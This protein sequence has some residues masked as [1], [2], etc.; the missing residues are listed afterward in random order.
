M[1]LD[2]VFAHPAANPGSSLVDAPAPL[3][4]VI[5][6]DDVPAGRRAL[7]ML[8]RVL[9]HD[10]AAVHLFPSLWRFDLLKDPEWRDDA[11]ADAITAN[12]LILSTS[13]QETIAEGI[14]GWVS[15]FLSCRRETDT[16][17]LA[18]FGPDDEWTISVQQ[19]EARPTQVEVGGGK[20]RRRVQAPAADSGSSCGRPG[21]A[22]AR[23]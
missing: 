12:L 7:A 21:G 17:I 23:R 8:D 9:Q 11:V 4:V 16:A 3:R 13:G 22:P 20:T 15:T 10:H 6:Y 1:Q 18:L 14:D 19:A 2:E 5:A